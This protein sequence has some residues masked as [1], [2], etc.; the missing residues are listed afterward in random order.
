MK[1]LPESIL[2]QQYKNYIPHILHHKASLGS[3]V[4]MFLAQLR[5]D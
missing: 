5:E 1:I 3:L 2:V 4:S